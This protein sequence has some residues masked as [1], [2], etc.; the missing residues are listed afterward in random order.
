[1]AGF[2][3]LSPTHSTLRRAPLARKSYNHRARETGTIGAGQ[4][5]VRSMREGWHLRLAHGWSVRGGSPLARQ[6]GQV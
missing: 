5:L 4:A 3:F 1:M 2:F 6:R